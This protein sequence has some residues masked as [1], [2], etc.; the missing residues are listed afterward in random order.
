MISGLMFML[1]ILQQTLK[2]H[3]DL[4]NKMNWQV[5]EKFNVDSSVL[6]APTFFPEWIRITSCDII[7]FSLYSVDD[8]H[9]LGE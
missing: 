6:F 7:Q 9:L 5:V 4:N 3:S 8:Y 1:S 2:Q